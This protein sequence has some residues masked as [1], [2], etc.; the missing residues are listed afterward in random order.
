MHPA[1]V[2]YS[3]CD[4]LARGL[5]AGWDNEACP[6]MGRGPLGVVMSIPA[7]DGPGGM[8]FQP[9][10]SQMHP[11][12]RKQI[13]FPH[14]VYVLAMVPPSWV[15]AIPH[16]YKHGSSAL[17]VPG[18]TRACQGITTNRMGQTELIV[19]EGIT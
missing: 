8:T 17:T 13:C 7:E 15:A 5:R 16:R 19:R 6:L 12:T 10:T 14:Y 2:C 9:Q 11:S 1:L 4:S 18:R 3:I